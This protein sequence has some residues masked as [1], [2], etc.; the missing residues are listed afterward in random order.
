M[1]QRPQLRLVVSN[2]FKPST[3]RNLPKLKPSPAS[4]S[5]S[6]AGVLLKVVRLNKRHPSAVA[7]LEKLIDDALDDLP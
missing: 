2:N 3:K 4:Y 1:S 5:A 7:L 6:C